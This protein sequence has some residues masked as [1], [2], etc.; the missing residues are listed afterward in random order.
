[1]SCLLEWWAAGLLL[2][3]RA[4]G[5]LCVQL[6]GLLGGG[7]ADVDE[8]ERADEAV[9][10]AEAAGAHDGVA[11][12]HGPVVL[13]QDERG[14]G[15]VGDLLEDVPGVLVG[16]DLYAV[17][18]RVG[19]CF[20]AGLEAFLALMPSPT[21]APTLLPSSMASSSERLLRCSTSN[22]PAASL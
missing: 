7:Q 11:Q 8:V 15:V 20:G 16:E 18:G 14:G 22:S 4:R 12:W 13:E 19:A 6:L 3:G 5:F 2:G 9:A 1:V 17:G 10:D 21:S